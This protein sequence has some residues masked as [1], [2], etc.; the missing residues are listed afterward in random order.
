MRILSYFGISY[1]SLLTNTVLLILIILKVF[2]AKPP[3]NLFLG[4]LLHS[5]SIGFFFFSLPLAMDI[6]ENSLMQEERKDLIKYL[7]FNASIVLVL[8]IFSFLIIFKF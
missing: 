8:N 5:I 7:N 4:T 1:I 3:I 6:Y 2:S